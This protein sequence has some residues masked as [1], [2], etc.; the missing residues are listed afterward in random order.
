MYIDE[1]MG[2]RYTM[3]FTYGSWAGWEQQALPIKNIYIGYSNS[4][5]P[6]W[7]CWNPLLLLAASNTP[8]IVVQPPIPFWLRW[9]C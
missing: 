5:Y 2:G 7:L 6:F 4:V 3:V 9:R 1:N 8:E